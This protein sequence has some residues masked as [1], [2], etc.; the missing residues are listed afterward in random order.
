MGARVAGTRGG[1][2]E[3]K[4]KE[5]G[6]SGGGDCGGNALGLLQPPATSFGSCT[7]QSM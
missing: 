6:W 3:D 2:K 7:C 5:K 4:G 1:R